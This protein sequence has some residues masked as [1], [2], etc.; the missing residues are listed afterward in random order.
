MSG[1]V[2]LPPF[3]ALASFLGTVSA[4]AQSAGADEAITSRGAVT[5]TVG[6]TS[7]QKIA[8][9]NAVL[10]QRA[11]ASSMRIEATVGAPVSRSVPLAELPDQTGIA[12]MTLLKY[13]MV[14][15]DVVV[16]DPIRMRV[17]DVIHGNIGQ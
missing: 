3:V 5:Q 2:R 4:V 10:R 17:V 12:D 16:V 11:R 14:A 1:W 6:L 15:D 8:I 7:A 13:A 9:Y